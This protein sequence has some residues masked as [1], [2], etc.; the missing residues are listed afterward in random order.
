[1]ISDF[2]D[3]ST[4]NVMMIFEK[5][6]NVDYSKLPKYDLIFTSPPYF[7]LEKYEGMEIFKDKEEFIEKFWRPT[8]EKAFKYLEKGG[9]IALNMPEEMYNAIKKYENP[10]NK[11]KLVVTGW[12]AI[13]HTYTRNNGNIHPVYAER[14]LLYKY[15]PDLPISISMLRSSG[16]PLVL[17]PM[18]NKPNEYRLIKSWGSSPLLQ[19]WAP[20]KDAEQALP[21]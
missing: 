21:L 13:Y 2:E 19:L 10:D 1:M 7:N 3:K 4:S 12:D 16:S 9:N 18:P 20:Q 14:K 11:V 6:Q 15:Y 5:S 8:I 17:G